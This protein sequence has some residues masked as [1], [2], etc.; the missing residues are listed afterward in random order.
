M[1]KPQTRW[2]NPCCQTVSTKHDDDHRI[3][4]LFFQAKKDLCI[5]NE[6]VYRDLFIKENLIFLNYSLLKNLSLKRI[7]EAKT[8]WQILEYKLVF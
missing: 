6:Q 2:P 4:I 7:D 3:K 5:N 1:E 8:T